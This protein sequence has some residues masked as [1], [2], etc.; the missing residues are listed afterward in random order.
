VHRQ[1]QRR[2]GARQRRPEALR[3]RNTDGRAPWALRRLSRPSL[4]EREEDRGADEDEVQAA[5]AVE[6]VEGARSVA[7]A[8]EADLPPHI[9][10]RTSGRRQKR[11]MKSA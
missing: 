2:R 3:T 9:E 11:R 8:G 7:Q 6:A 5:E 10:G 4:Q 1:P